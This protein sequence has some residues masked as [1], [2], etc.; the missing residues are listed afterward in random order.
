[1]NKNF[2]MVA[3][4]LAIAAALGYFFLV[5]P[6]QMT[7]TTP[8][9]QDAM[10]PKESENFIVSAQNN[11]GQAGTMT[12]TRDDA[13]MA[14]VTLSLTGGEFEMPQPAHIHTGRCPQP[15]GVVYP[16][17]NVTGGSSVT[18]LDVSYEDL[19]T[20]LKANQHAVNVHKSAAESKSYTACGDLY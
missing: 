16:L 11:S 5:A 14:V 15:G 8:D 17:E 13:G 3:V 18:T 10:A 12:I 19:I 4:I 6:K 2:V 9:A 20:T 1:M 7:S